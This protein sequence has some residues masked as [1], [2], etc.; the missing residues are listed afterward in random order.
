MV[1]RRIG[2]TTRIPFHNGRAI[3]VIV[4]VYIYINIYVY[5][6]SFY[7][8]R[9]DVGQRLKTLQM[10]WRRCR[11]SNVW[12]FV[13]NHNTVR[14]RIRLLVYWISTPFDRIVPFPLTTR[15]E[16][17]RIVR[18]ENVYESRL[19]L[20]RITRAFLYMIHIYS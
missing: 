7:L 4:F 8:I 17:R 1:L 11:H 5:N 13:I 16:R 3:V 2:R 10:I 14:T 18:D 19:L 6:W 20:M 15:T 12:P 9:L